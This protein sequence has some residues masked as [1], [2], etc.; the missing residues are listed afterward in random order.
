MNDQ[1]FLNTLALKIISQKNHYFFLFHL[2]TGNL[3]KK[4][5]HGHPN[6]TLGVVTTT[7]M[8]HRTSHLRDG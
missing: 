6:E 2:D 1:I 4:K 3:L 7:P 8:K 5:L